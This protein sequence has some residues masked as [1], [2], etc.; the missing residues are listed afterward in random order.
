MSEKASFVL[1]QVALGTEGSRYSCY[2]R[3]GCCSVV[4]GASNYGAAESEDTTKPE[5]AVVMD[6][7]KFMLYL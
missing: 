6:A 4:R 2:R 3:L 1:V 7:G 5:E